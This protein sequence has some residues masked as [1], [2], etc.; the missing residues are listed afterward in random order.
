MEQNDWELSRIKFTHC[1]PFLIPFLIIYLQTNFWWFFNFNI[2]FGFF[3]GE[4]SIEVS[5]ES[6]VCFLIFIWSDKDEVGGA[7]SSFNLEEE[8]ETG[9][10]IKS[11]KWSFRFTELIGSLTEDV[12]LESIAAPANIKVN[13]DV[14]EFRGGIRLLCEELKGTDVDFFEGEPKL[15]TGGDDESSSVIASCITD[16]LTLSDSLDFSSEGKCTEGL[17][18]A[19]NLRGTVD[20]RTQGSMLSGGAKWLDQEM[21]EE[22]CCLQVASCIYIILRVG[23]SGRGCRRDLGRSRGSNVAII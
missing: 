9:D 4:G 1:V 8:D 18:L 12:M 7:A 14:G 19:F 22:R 5:L 2:F 3:I 10:L 21:R 11:S 17:G 15:I 6:S 20:L 16:F 13:G 23:E